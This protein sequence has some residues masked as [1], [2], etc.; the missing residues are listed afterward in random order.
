M[1]KIYYHKLIRDRIP[2]FIKKKDTRYAVKKLSTKRFEEE[3]YK[4]VGEEATGLLSAKNKQ[5]LASELADIH[6]VLETIRKYKKS[7][8]PVSLAS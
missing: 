8:H 7:N 5:E 6:E 1:K 2:D 3:L 4:K